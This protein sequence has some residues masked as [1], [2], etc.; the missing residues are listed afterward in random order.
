[1]SIGNEFYICLPEVFGVLFLF[2]CLFVFALIL[3]GYTQS[4][5]GIKVFEL[6]GVLLFSVL[7]YFC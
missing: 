1:M 5:I 6:H 4:R 2:V 3:E 7:H